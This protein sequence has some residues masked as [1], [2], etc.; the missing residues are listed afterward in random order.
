MET[1]TAINKIEVADILS[2]YSDKFIK[3]HNLSFQQIKTIKAI[4]S[5]R[6]ATLGYHKLVCN[7]CNYEQISYNSCRNRHCPKCQSTKQLKWIDKLKAQVLPIRYFHIAFTLPIQIRPLAYINQ[8]IVYS[9]LFRAASQTLKQVALNPK[10]LGAEPAFLAVLH[11][12]GQNLSYHP[13]LHLIVSAGGLDPDGL[14]WKQ[15]GS[16]FFVPVKALSKVFRAKF[17]T[18]LKDEYKNNTL[19]IPDTIDDL[20]YSDLKKLTSLLYSKTWNVYSK[21]TFRGAGNVIEYLGRYTHKVA[22]AN[23]RIISSDKGMV[24]FRYKD[25]RD[26]KSKIIELTTIEFIRR[27][28]QHILP[29]N[30]YK[31]RYFGLLANKNRTTKL[32]T[33]FSLLKINIPIPKFEGLCFHEIIKAVTG[34]DIFICPACKRGHLILAST[35]EFNTE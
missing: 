28:V 15:S 31:I 26:N 13:H 19:K 24:K 23:S 27:F 21:K 25:Y 17:I 16:K 8:N 30:F 3:E 2:T 10:F 1:K 29:N 4:K 12:W 32:I 5:C 20:D 34:N 35:L 18:M 7:E 14:E 22:I 11:T 6:T 33:C 9:I